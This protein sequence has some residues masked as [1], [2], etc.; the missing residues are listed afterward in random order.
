MTRSDFGR[1]VWGQG[2]EGAADRLKSLTVGGV[3]KMQSAGFTKEMAEQWR[4][5]YANDLARN[6]NNATAVNRISLLDGIIG[7][8]K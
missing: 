7:H 1:L 3:E 6:A 5:F 8:M 2:P 4:A